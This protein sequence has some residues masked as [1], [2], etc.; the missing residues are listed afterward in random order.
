MSDPRANRLAGETS[1]YLLQHAHNPVDWYPWGDEALERSRREDKPIL[2][3]IGYAACHW[4]H[5]MERESFEDVAIARQMNENFVCIK[6]DREERPDLDDIYMTAVQMI[7]GHGGWPLTVFLTPDLR[8]F[9][10]GTYFPPDDRMGMP[11]FR[12]LLRVISASYENQRSRVEATGTEITERLQRTTGAER[13]LEI[14]TTELIVSAVAELRGRFDARYGGFSPAPKFPHSTLISLLL[15]YAGQHGNQE[16]LRMATVTLDRMACGGIHDHIGGGFHRYST[17]ERWLVPH[18]EKMLYDNALLAGAYLEAYQA[19]DNESYGQ[20]AGA[21][22]DWAMREMQGAKGGFYSTLDA[23][24]EGEEGRFYVWSRAEIERLLGEDAEAFCRVYD[25][26]TDGN[27]EGRNILNLKRPMREAP[28]ELRKEL[29][30]EAAQLGELLQRCRRTLLETRDKR[31]RPG[32]DD[33][34][35]T[36]WNGLMIAAM[37]C[38]YRVLGESSYLRSAERAVRFVLDAMV[39]EERLLHSYRHGQ[40]KLLAYLD[41]YANMLWALVELHE[42]SRDPHWLAQ[43]RWL[44]DQLI[45][46]FWDDG[47]AAFFFTGSDHEQLIARML[48]GHDGATPS[49][50]GVAATAL[51]RLATITGENAYARRATDILHTFQGQM[52]R[53]PSA[54]SQML[55]ALDEYLRTPQ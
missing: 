10:G 9:Y 3:S 31:V 13:S 7:S 45:A 25:V 29:G 4:C 38:G 19:T 33:K 15:R 1:P 35:L 43:A 39:R 46:L 44:A 50:N 41:D 2:L 17:D 47:Q 54:F 34:I 30:I 36:D 49:G 24:S 5:V 53:S 40:G 48:R 51:L 42:T 27:W 23:D 28:D 55:I 8:P 12:S 6:V 52:R 14:L 20:V 22:L 37:A 18:F 21:I 11:G 16:A 32:L 26:T